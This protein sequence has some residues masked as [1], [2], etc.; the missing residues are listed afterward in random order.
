M[1]AIAA[2]VARWRLALRLQRHRGRLGGR[3]GIGSGSSQEFFDF[4]D[5]AP[6]DDLRHVDWRGFARTE[7]L[8]VRLFEAEVAPY[9][10]VV[11][12]PSAS[13]AVTDQ[14]AAAARALLGVLL[15]L[16]R[17]EQAQAQ[18]QALGVGRIDPERIAFTSTVDS[19]GPLLAPLRA[20]GLRVLLTDG[21]W[22]TGGT[23][24]LRTL[25][26]SASWF[27]CVQLLDPWEAAPTVGDTLQLVDC[28]T[29]ATHERRLDRATVAEYTTRLQRLTDELRATVVGSGGVFARVLA[30][31]PDVMVARDLAAAGVVEPA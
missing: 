13:L 17:G 20:Q 3:R 18:V 12:D 21:L 27:L 8:R 5:Y 15:G 1:N 26:A 22:R 25:A 11:V 30:D 28:E 16:L 2:V 29:G 24:L 10:D 19:P 14:K 23:A 7:Q 4:R 31:A 6:G 9:C